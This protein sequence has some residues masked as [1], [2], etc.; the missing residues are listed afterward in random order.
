MPEGFPSCSTSSVH[1][2]DA[3]NTQIN[4]IDLYL[5]L[6]SYFF[7]KF[8]THYSLYSDAIWRH[9]S[10]STVVQEMACCLMATSN[11]LNKSWLTTNGIQWRSHERN[12]TEQKRPKIPISKTRLKITLLK[13]YCH[14][15]LAPWGNISLP[16]KKQSPTLSTDAP[17]SWHLA[18]VS[19]S[20]VESQ[21]VMTTRA[22]SRAKVT[23]TSAPIP[24]VD[25][26]M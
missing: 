19:W 1:T 18:T 23:A 9:R 22:P 15:S 13:V 16:P 21:P 6:F 17:A 3:G 5:R 25:P 7:I 8:K 4:F 10:G 20:P 14:I 12:F 24:E 26:W 2:R 11:Q